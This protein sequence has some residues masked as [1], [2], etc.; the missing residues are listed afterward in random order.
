[1]GRTKLRGS[2]SL[3][4]IGKQIFA[5]VGNGTDDDDDMFGA[6]Y[7]VSTDISTYNVLDVGYPKRSLV[8]LNDSL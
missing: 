5:P 4:E 1:M 7:N 3:L 6:R 2:W 8:V